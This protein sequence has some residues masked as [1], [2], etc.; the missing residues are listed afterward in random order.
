MEYKLIKGEKLE[1]RGVEESKRSPRDCIQ[2]SRV[3]GTERPI[4]KSSAMCSS[5]TILLKRQLS[6]SKGVKNFPPSH[7]EA[8]G[9]DYCPQMTDP[10]GEYCV[11]LFVKVSH[12]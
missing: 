12:A 5:D 4:I 6:L 3:W 7:C 1:E 10:S 9:K 2:H 8:L 11:K